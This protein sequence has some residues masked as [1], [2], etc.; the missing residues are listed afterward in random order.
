MMQHGRTKAGLR[1]TMAPAEKRATCSIGAVAIVA[2][3][4]GGYF[5]SSLP[6]ILSRASMVRMKTRV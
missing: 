4:Q 1:V 3:L 5:A 6:A 2:S